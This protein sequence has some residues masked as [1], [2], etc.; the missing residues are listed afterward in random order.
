[1]NTHTTH[2]QSAL[3]LASTLLRG[4]AL[5]VLAVGALALASAPPAAAGTYPMYQCVPGSEAVSPGWSVYGV[6]TNASTTLWDTCSSGGAIGDYVFSDGEAGAVTENGSS[7]SQVGLEIDVPGSAP[8]VSIQSIAAEVIG[9]SVT[10]DDAFM[11][12]TSAGQLLPGEVELPYGGSNYT[13][14]ESWSLP[15]GA[16]DFEAHVNCTTDHSSPTCDFADTIAV[17]ALTDITLTLVDDTPPAV[18]SASGSLATAAAHDSTVT[19]T[20]TLSFAGSDADSGVR[21]ATLTLTP[22]GGQEPY[23]HTFDFSGECAYDSWNACPLSESLS[24]FTLNTA[25]LKDDSYTANLSITDAAGNTASDPLGTL[26]TDNAPTNTSVPT[27]LVPGQVLVGG[28]LTTHPGTWTAPSG[29]GAI[30]YS[31]Q[32]EQCDTQGNNCQLI[33]GAQNPTYTPAPSDIGHTLRLIL[34]ASDNDGLTPA[35]TTPTSV[36]LSQQ[37]TLGALPGPG[38]GSSSGDVG[39]GGSSVVLVGVGTP[40]GSSATESATIRLGVHRK[41]SRSFAQRAFKLPGRLLDSNGH[42][43]NAAEL[44]ILQQTAGSTVLKVIG[45]TRTLANG[46]F[47]T[48]V[49]VGPSRVIEVAYRAFSAD[50][51]YTTTDQITESVAAGVHLKIAPRQTYPNGTIVLTGQVLGPIPPQG[52][53]VE[54]IVH[55]HGHWVP[56]R[57]PRTETDGHFEVEYQFEGGVGNFPFRAVVPAGQA[58]FPFS[59]GSSNK[60][61]VRTD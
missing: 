60:V 32:W 4:A 19:G 1:M 8:D 30:T 37:G 34:S 39:G 50:T 40:N 42:P 43:I 25:T 53:R 61:D 56:F 36:V 17:P 47:L 54:L 31:Y 33:A 52:T 23:T 14:S 10:S 3:L 29:T 27:I 45:H 21:S 20:Q 28:E 46:T 22:Q 38:T 57:T 11:G 44:D 49:P 2:T 6:D 7:G 59:S 18:T 9:S 41:I 48:H 12:F 55:Y 58:G 5:L 13:T 16:R 15:Q 51:N 35:T 24:G 26:V